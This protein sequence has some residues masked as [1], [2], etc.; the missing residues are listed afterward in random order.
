MSFAIS[1]DRNRENGGL[2]RE[3]NGVLEYALN[4]LNEKMWSA[5]VKTKWSPP[6]G[7]FKKSGKA[8]ARGIMAAS[9][10]KRQ[11]MSR[12]NFYINRAGKNLSDADRERLLVAKAIIGR[13]SESGEDLGVS[14]SDVN[15]F[16]ADAVLSLS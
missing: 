5:G 16:L 1:D 8:I 2:V 10:N 6:E 9:R 11:A 15:E 3:A 14:L 12:L 13:M 7:L 4:L